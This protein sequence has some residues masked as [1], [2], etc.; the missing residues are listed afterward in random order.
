V[1]FHN[2]AAITGTGGWSAYETLNVRGTGNAIAAARSSGARLLQLSSVAVYGTAQRFNTPGTPIAE[3]AD[4]GPLRDEAFY[5]RSK[6]ESERMVLDA[7]RS[8]RIWGTAVRPAVIYG[9]R[10]R[11]FVP[12]L[13]LL[14]ST[15]VAPIIGG[16]N[17]NLG[18]VHA[19]N[20]ADGA[21]LAATLD[22]AGGQAYNLANDFDVTT[23]EYLELAA[24]GLDRR[25]RLLPVPLPVARSGW[26]L[27]RAVDVLLLRRRFSVATAGSIDFLSRDNP[28]TSERARRELG[29]TPRAAPPDGVPEAF[30]WWRD[31]RRRAR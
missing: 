7:H 2:A 31:N 6:R 3:D 4:L 24:R 20:V 11:Q 19:A 5:S 18:V 13:A 14:L 10:D 22:I 30:R 15:G 1:I 28:F 9:K 26:Q 25:V 16:G 27:I 12:R 21:N 29:W 17:N 8:G 23:R